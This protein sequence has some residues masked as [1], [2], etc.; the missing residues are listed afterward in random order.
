MWPFKT[1]KKD[2]TWPMQPMVLQMAGAILQLSP[3]QRPQ[4]IAKMVERCIRMGARLAVEFG[5]PAPLFVEIAKAQI[6]REG[7]AKAKAALEASSP[8]EVVPT[9]DDVEGAVAAVQGQVA[10]I[11]SGGS[12]GTDEE[13]DEEMP[14]A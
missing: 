14:E 9:L 11:F 6:A 4:G 2:S 3:E 1:L 12:G 8:P 13:T 10:E 7:G 5:V